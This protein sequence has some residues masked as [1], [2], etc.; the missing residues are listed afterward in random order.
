[1]KNLLLLVVGALLGA[2]SLFY[3]HLK[4]APIPEIEHHTDV[5][6]AYAQFAAAVGEAGEFVQAHQWYGSEREQAEA[7]RHIAR[8]LMSSIPE[9]LLID[10]DFPDFYE[11][12]PFNKSGMDNSDQRYL[13][14]IVD[15]AGNYR[16][17]GRRGTSRRLEVSVYEEDAM[18]KTLA[19]LDASQLIVDE[20]GAFEIILGGE[21][22]AGNWLPLQPGRK[23]VLV[24]QIFSNWD[25]ERPGDVHID[26]ID[27]GRPLYPVMNNKE[28]AER[29][30]RTT[31]LFA[32]NVRRWPE[33]SRTRFDALMPANRLTPPQNVADSGGLA[34]RVMV[35]GHFNLKPNEAMVIKAWPTEANYQ[36]IQLGHHWWESLDYANRQSSLTADQAAVSADGAIY[37][38]I[39]QE[40]P[41]TANW[42]DTEGF[43]RGVILMRYDGIAGARLASEQKPTARVVKLS[44]LER[45]LPVNEPKV[46]P[47][48]RSEQ[49]RKRREHVQRRFGL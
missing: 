26:R 40:D 8:V 5:A 27:R 30:V 49:T 19:S 31:N 14:T 7:Y 22:R 25:V 23:R 24:R 21:E 38:V 48:Q 36:G 37:Y 1:M 43:S 47:D 28:M 18:S 29:L 2:G 41:G 4:P 3:F 17:W 10:K 45:V 39:A 32:T 13:S 15:G 42:L 34:G 6:A 35:G 9:A 16:V 46:N 44:D 20:K 33:Y 11:I 12:G